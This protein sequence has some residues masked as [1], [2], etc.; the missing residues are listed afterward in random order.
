MKKKNII[1]IFL[2]ACS[3]FLVGCSKIGLS[4]TGTNNSPEIEVN[5]QSIENN[6]SLNSVAPPDGPS[7]N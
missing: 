7:E 3:F 4:G 2:I 1:P 5:D 6:S